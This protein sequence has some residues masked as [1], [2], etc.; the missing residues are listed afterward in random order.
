MASSRP[1]RGF[2]VSDHDVAAEQRVRRWKVAAC[3]AA[4]LAVLTAG[5]GGAWYLTPPPLPESIAEADALV[6]SAR[7][8]RL[9]RE[10]QRPYLDVI[11]E[12]FG[13]LDAEQRRT[14]RNSEAARAARSDERQEFMNAFSVM[15]FQERQAV[16]NPWGNR[17]GGRPPGA[18]RPGGTEGGGGGGAGGG[19][20]GGAGDGARG[21]GE[22]SGAGRGDG[23]RGPSR[24]RLSES[25]Q[26]G[27]AQRMAN[28]A[29]MVNQARE[30][31]DR[32]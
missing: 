11:R 9:G 19:G 14:M 7:F 16:G 18:G 4:A 26:S 17:D 1:P 2:T 24:E 10:E 8:K 12:Q 21:G 20:G 29:E 15:S 5:A 3:V 22:G 6:A 27:S 31:R 25:M 32:P 30:T 28:V 13:S 23:Q